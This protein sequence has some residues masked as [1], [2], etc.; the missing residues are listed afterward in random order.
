MSAVSVTNDA[1]IRYRFTEIAVH[2]QVKA[3]NSRKY[4]VLFLGTD[5]G[6]VLKAASKDQSDYAVVIEDL[7]VFPMGS[8]VV[9]L[10]LLVGAEA[11]ELNKLVVVSRDEVKLMPLHRC[12]NRTK[13]RSVLRIT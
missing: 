9:S 3:A 10:K 7:E 1:C 13:R 4:D 5:N 11:G 12:E 6:H 2:W 8:S